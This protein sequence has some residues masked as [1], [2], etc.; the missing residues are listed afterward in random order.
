[1][2]ELTEYFLKWTAAT[3]VESTK[4]CSAL[5]KGIWIVVLLTFLFIA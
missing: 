5:T 1:L 2:I 4:A 3:K